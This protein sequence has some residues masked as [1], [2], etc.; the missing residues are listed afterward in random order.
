MARVLER[1]EV[2]DTQTHHC[3]GLE[4]VIYEAR[5]NWLEAQSVNV[6]VS[7]GADDELE[8]RH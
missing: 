1:L 5:M 3:F 2:A 4:K 7:V 6:N 8:S